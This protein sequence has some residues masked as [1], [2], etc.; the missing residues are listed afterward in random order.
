MVHFVENIVEIAQIIKAGNITYL[1]DGMLLGQKQFTDIIH[2]F[3]VYIFCRR[4]L[5]IFLKGT[6]DMGLW[7]IAQLVNPF[8]AFDIVIPDTHLFIQLNHPLW[9]FLGLQADRRV[10]VHYKG[11][12]NGGYKRTEQRAAFPVGKKLRK[13]SKLGCQIFKFISCDFQVDRKFR[14]SNDGKRNFEIPQYGKKIV[15]QISYVEQFEIKVVE[16]L[17]A[18]YVFRAYINQ[19]ALRQ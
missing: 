14:F 4:H 19:G 1:W 8:C 12:I 15:G 13:F 18:V 16:C 2:T 5:E 7:V 3:A 6:D 11:I 10:S 17:V 9:N